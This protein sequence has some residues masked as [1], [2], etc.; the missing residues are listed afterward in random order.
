VAEDNPF[1]RPA[2]TP[3]NPF[4][5]PAATP[6]NPF[7][8]PAATPDNLLSRP[9]EP[10]PLRGGAGSLPQRSPGVAGGPLD[11]PVG[12][13]NGFTPTRQ[14]AQPAPGAGP[15]PP[16]R[17]GGSP[18]DR[19]ASAPLDRPPF[20]APT[21]QPGPGT[22]TGQPGPGTPAG[23]PALGTP[24]G[25]S[26]FGA[27]A[28][29]APWG[30]AGRP[31]LGSR[32][33]GAAAGVPF[34][35]GSSDDDSRP[36]DRP[37]GVSVFGD[38]RVRVPGATLDGLPEAPPAG[39]D[40]GS[41][42]AP[43]GSVPAPGGS[44]PARGGSFPARGGSVP[45]RGESVPARGESFPARGESVPARGESFPARGESFPARGE[46]FPARGGSFP[47]GGGESGGFPAGGEGSG[48]PIR[49]GS[50]NGSFPIRGAGARGVGGDFAGGDADGNV[51][52]GRAGAFAGD[53]APRPDVDSDGFPTR[54][55]SDSNP[56]RDGTF[57]RDDA[58]GGLPAPGT[59]NS[60]SFPMRGAPD[61]DRD[62]PGSPR[63]LSGAPDDLP[64]RRG[65][66]DRADQG[67]E[68]SGGTGYAQRIPGASFASAGPPDAGHPDSSG[69]PQ[70]VPGAS[71]G[72]GGS[73]VLAEPRSAAA[74]PQPRD[75][76]E[77]PEFGQPPAAAERPAK[78]TARPVSAS[79]SVPVASRV[80]PPSDA[81]EVPPPPVAGPQ[82]RV[83]GRPA[84]AEEQ[85]PYRD[86]EQPVI[87]AF[88]AAPTSGARDT[89][90]TSGAYGQAPPSQAPQS[91]APP[92][93]APQSPASRSQAPQSPA[94]RSQAPQS[95]ASR[96][97][98]PQSP[99][100]RSQ[101]PQSPAPES[102][103]PEDWTPE[104]PYGRPGDGTYGKPA[105]D[106]YGRPPEPPFGTRPSSGASPFDEG[107][108]DRSNP[109]APRL[110]SGSFAAPEHGGPAADAP[111]PYPPGAVP[112]SGG[113]QASGRVSGRATASARV[114]PPPPGQPFAP[115]SP[116]PGQASD[117]APFSEFT[118]DIAGRGRSGQP[119]QP[120][121]VPG[122]PAARTVPPDQY[123]ENTTDVSG[124][125]QGAEQ[126]YVPAPALPSMHAAPP[127]ENGFP[128]AQAPESSQPFGE[129][130]R[131]GGVFPGPAS[132][133]TVTPPGPDQT[134]SWPGQPEPDADRSRFDSFK[135]DAPEAVP[136]E[137]TKPETPHVRLLPVILGV[138]LGAGLLVGLTLGVTWLI[139]RGS[140]EDG[141][142]FSVS[143]GDCVKRNG[144]EAVTANCGD[145]GSFEVTALVNTKEE[146]PD[147]NQPY[148]VNPTD[149]GRTQVL[150]LKPRG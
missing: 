5:R 37:P 29:Q 20:G 79:A 82:P 57:R 117:A 66:G 64:V 108:D 25:Q 114:T 127:L 55:G 85:P 135:P 12:E 58:G 38:Q 100:S 110:P 70:R 137:V 1:T 145:A 123:G 104:S 144:N 32:E 87:G 73:P 128:A 86:E 115:A 34:G 88:G 52:P 119:D 124:R 14:P 15:E 132:R 13:F 105:A 103:A 54:S 44:V 18:F 7:T 3:D 36:G 8:R 26:A 21:G 23:Q 68:P 19:Q 50:G 17:P 131:M 41:F 48:F 10:Q 42:T 39:P 95:P 111:P 45:A 9:A 74:V 149:N 116:A 6:D 27:S 93:Q 63:P 91:Q 83:Y 121:S 59:S 72:T 109:F 46:S 16:R 120:G 122:S 146:C 4:T 99:A 96:S 30:A 62:Q 28:D 113:A 136:T 126:P 147:P 61:G 75:S 56:F 40:G 125:G 143:A 94:S 43:G 71:L 47:A 102:R 112:T 90:P 107:G 69:Y 84:P 78:G 49:G 2:A 101:A 60:G 65:V 92:S 141:G 77:R 106:L 35:S 67:A 81:D 89:A 98:A 22:P 31:P 134:A 142:G 133:A 51:F 150:C 129:R 80:I 148:V 130:P 140:H 97:Q 53:G 24:A 118:T 76:S 33:P 11:G 139:A 138:I